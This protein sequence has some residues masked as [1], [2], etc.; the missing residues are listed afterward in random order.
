MLG[1]V[2]PGIG[3]AVG[4][5]VGG[6]IGGLGGLFSGNAADRSIQAQQN[7]AM[8]QLEEARGARQ[9]ALGRAAASESELDLQRALTGMRRQILG[10]GER[11]LQF[12][13][14]GLD[15]RQPG[16]YEQ[17]AGLFSSVLLRQRQ[18]QRSLLESS[19]RQRFGAGFATTSAGQQALQ[20]FDMGTSDL[21][22]Q[23]IPTVLQ[24]Q[25][26]AINQESQLQNLIKNREINASIGTPIAQYQGAQFTGD[27]LR[28]QRDQ[29]NIG[30]I[31]QLGGTLAGM[32]Y[33][34]AK[35]TNPQGAI[36]GAQIGSQMMGSS[37]W[38][39]VATDLTTPRLNFGFLKNQ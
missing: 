8:A 20:Q 4:G 7:V 19:L 12:L 31:L 18:A 16:A 14:A 29:Q 36:T 9:F 26:S 32:S 21:A 24:T 11:E 2:V 33:G 39:Q 5:V 25:Y 30:S 6:L 38:G 17:G 22:T 28:A 34:Q 15:M 35:I 37:P 3:T 10:Q 27:I 1:S 13:Q 23:M